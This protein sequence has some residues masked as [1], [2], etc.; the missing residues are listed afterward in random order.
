[1][2]IIIYTFGFPVVAM[3]EPHPCREPHPR[4]S[5]YASLVK[6]VIIHHAE[7]ESLENQVVGGNGDPKRPDRLALGMVGLTQAS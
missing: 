7:G 5:R 3:G 6:D 4:K 2:Q 1:M